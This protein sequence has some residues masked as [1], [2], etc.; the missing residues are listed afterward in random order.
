MLPDLAPDDIEN[1]N[2]VFGT[3]HDQGFPTIGSPVTTL[4]PPLGRGC[5]ALQAQTNPHVAIS[6]N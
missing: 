3:P 6:D 5:E 4:E 2:L 1:R